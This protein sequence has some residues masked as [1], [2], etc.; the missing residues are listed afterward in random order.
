MAPA[1]GKPGL[2]YGEVAGLAG[3]GVVLPDAVEA[4]TVG[5]FPV[6]PALGVDYAAVGEAEE[7]FSCGVFNIDELV[8]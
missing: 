4:D 3:D 7:E 8:Y 1:R 6:V 5:P 2:D